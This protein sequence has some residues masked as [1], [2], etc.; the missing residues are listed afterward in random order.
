MNVNMVVQRGRI[1]SGGAISDHDV[2]I[3]SY[4]HI[5]A[6]AIVKAGARVESGRKLEVGE[7]VLGYGAAKDKLNELWV[8][9]HKDQ[10]GIGPS[11]M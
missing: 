8:K 4:V 9:E 10:F 7:V 2:V 6:G 1:I 11:F 5:N 3:D